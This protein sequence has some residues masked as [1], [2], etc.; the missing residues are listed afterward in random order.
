ML[1][2]NPIAASY[3]SSGA[4]PEAQAARDSQAVKEL[5]QFFVLQLLKEMRKSIPKDGL[6]PSGFESETYDE[7]LDDAFSKEITE[8]GQFGISKL[9]EEQLRIADMQRSFHASRGMMDAL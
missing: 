9:I 8:S 6:F 3:A 5:E 7:M 2:V 1:Y 4:D